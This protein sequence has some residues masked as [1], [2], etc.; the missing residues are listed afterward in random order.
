MGTGAKAY[1]REWYFYRSLNSTVL[2]NKAKNPQSVMDGDFC[3]MG[4]FASMDSIGGFEEINLCI[5]LV[6]GAAIAG[7]MEAI[8]TG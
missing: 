8:L 2:N 6:F 3:F 5:L 7:I 1:R 4:C